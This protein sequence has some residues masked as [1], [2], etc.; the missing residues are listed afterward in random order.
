M[1]KISHTRFDR[2]VTPCVDCAENKRLLFPFLAP[3]RT[4]E[5]RQRSPMCKFR[6]SEERVGK[7]RRGEVGV[8]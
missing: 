7:G 3:L 4:S 6:S 5:D 8:E 2:D 1:E